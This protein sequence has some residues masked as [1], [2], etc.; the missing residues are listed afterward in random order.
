M[1]SHVISGKL[2]LPAEKIQVAFSQ[3]LPPVEDVQR[4]RLLRT[5]TLQA[6]QIETWAK[7]VTEVELLT[8]ADIYV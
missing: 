2:Q 4:D 6:V 5:A 3:V 8:D 7:A 1:S